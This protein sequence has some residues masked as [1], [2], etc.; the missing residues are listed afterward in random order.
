MGARDEPQELSSFWTE[1]RI[2]AGA[3]DTVT[4]DGEGSTLNDQGQLVAGE[5]G[6]ATVNISD[7]AA[8]SIGAEVDPS[9]TDSLQLGLNDGGTGTME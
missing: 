8:V 7:G 4:V 3:T 1:N 6:T 2:P 9:N 5:G